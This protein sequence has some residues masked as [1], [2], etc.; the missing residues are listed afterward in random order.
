MIDESKHLYDFRQQIK[1]MRYKQEFDV[2]VERYTEIANLKGFT[3]MLDE[4]VTIKNIQVTNALGLL[5]SNTPQRLIKLG[6]PY[7]SIPITFARDGYWLTPDDD[8]YT[9]SAN[10]GT[11]ARIHKKSFR[12]VSSSQVT[13]IMMDNG[14][15]QNF[16][17]NRIKNKLNNIEYE[18]AIA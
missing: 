2:I 7:G 9:T 4:I 12:T 13:N 10:H 6:I 14:K 17:I 11:T 18:K 16:T 1:S 15:Y 8:V 5:E 3:A